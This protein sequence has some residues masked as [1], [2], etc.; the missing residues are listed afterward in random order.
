MIVSDASVQKDG[1]SSFAWVI[2]NGVTPVWRG[3]GL[4]PG[5]EED[6]YSS[7]AEAFGLLAA[8]LYLKYYLS[9]YTHEVPA[10][11][12]HT[13]CDNLGVIKVLTAMQSDIIQ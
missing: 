9:C 6:M 12:I 11:T 5:P 4:A 13:Y 1:H 3:M 8:T 10:T 2:A 7:C